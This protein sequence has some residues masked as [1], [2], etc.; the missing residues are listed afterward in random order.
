MA[1][2]NLPESTFDDDALRER[3]LGE[4]Y[5]LRAYYYHQ[6]TRYYGGAPIIDRPYGLGEDYSAPRGTYAELVDFMISDLDQ[7]IS[8]LDG[9]PTTAGRASML[10]AM[11]LI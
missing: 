11:G 7:A 3:L 6:L 10:S 2:E 4:A 1:I 5:F 8:L 9:K